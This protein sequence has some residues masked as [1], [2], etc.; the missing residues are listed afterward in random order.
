VLGYRPSP[1]GLSAAGPGSCSV[2]SHGGTLPLALAALVM[3]LASCLAC[4]DSIYVVPCC[5]SKLFWLLAA[6]ADWP[7]YLR[8][9]R[10][11]VW[12]TIGPLITA[13]WPLDRFRRPRRVGFMEFFSA[14]SGRSGRGD[15]CCCRVSPAGRLTGCFDPARLQPAGF[16]RGCCCLPL[17]AQVPDACAAMWRQEVSLLPGEPTTTSRR[18]SLISWWS[19]K[20]LAS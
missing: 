1:A 8:V 14:P 15:A 17:P 5:A 10:P 13:G 18:V 19:R 6:W 2:W 20:D 4:A 12:L 7:N 11:D 9:G 3:A 16:R